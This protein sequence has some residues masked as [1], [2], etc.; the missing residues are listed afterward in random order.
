MEFDDVGRLSSSFFGAVIKV[1][2]GGGGGGGDSCRWPSLKA[3]QPSVMRGRLSLF[4]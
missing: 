2:G 1:G 3:R 4:T